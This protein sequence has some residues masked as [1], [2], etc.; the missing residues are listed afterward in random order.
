[1]KK[2]KRALIRVGDRDMHCFNAPRVGC[3][4]RAGTS[5]FLWVGQLG[6]VASVVDEK[7]DEDGGLMVVWLGLYARVSEGESWA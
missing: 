4:P 3:R 1:M 2:K 6:D 5:G 7:N